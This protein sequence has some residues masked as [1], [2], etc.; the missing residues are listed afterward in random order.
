MD[1]TQG[2]TVGAAAAKGWMDAGTEVDDTQ[3]LAAWDAMC[4][5]AGEEVRDEFLIECPPMVLQWAYQTTA[6][7]YT[8][9]SQGGQ[10]QVYLDGQ[11]IS[12]QAAIGGILRRN[13]ALLGR[14][15]ANRVTIVGPT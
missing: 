9:R 5:Y 15:A 13:R 11:V 14:Y 3:L 7:F 8:S 12:G 2:S 4:D 6:D 10:G 1:L